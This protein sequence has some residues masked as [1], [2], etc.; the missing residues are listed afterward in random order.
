MLA[1]PLGQR[2]VDACLPTTPGGFE[3]L[4]HTWIQ[5]DLRPFINRLW[6]RVDILF[7]GSS[8][9]RIFLMGGMDARLKL[10][11]DVLLP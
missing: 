5:A 8:N 1:C 11:H 10:R 9:A 7:G 4:Q 2:L 3:R 6:L